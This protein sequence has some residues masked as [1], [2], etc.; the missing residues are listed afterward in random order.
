MLYTDGM[1][2]FL[3][4]PDTRTIIQEDFDGQPNSLYSL[5]NS[6]LVDSHAIL[7]DHMV[8]SGN[9]AFEREE[10]PFFLGEKLLF[11]KALVTGYEGLED[12]DATITSND[13]KALLQFEIPEFYE[14]TLALLPKNFSFEEHFDLQIEDTSET[15]TPEWV[16]YVFNMADTDTKAYFLDHLKET[17][18]QGKHVADYLKKMGEQAIKSMR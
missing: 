8:Y 7:N 13:L 1:K 14:K 5:F 2:T 15:V 17:V 12:L 18:E 11:G 16:L 3:I 9:E 10:V 4:D 6:L